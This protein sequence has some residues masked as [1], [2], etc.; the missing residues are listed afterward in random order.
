MTIEFVDFKEQMTIKEAI[1]HT[2]KIGIN[3]ESLVACFI[4]NKERVLKGLY[5]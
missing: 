5:P 4:I 3:K 2:R 1:N